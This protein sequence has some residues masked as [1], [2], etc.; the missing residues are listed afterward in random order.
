[1]TRGGAGAASS[2]CT[3]GCDQERDAAEEQVG[4]HRVCVTW[5][6]VM[7]GAGIRAL[8]A[9]VE[10]LDLPEPREPEATEVLIE[11]RAAG[12]GN[13]DEIA[14]NG[15]WDLGIVPPMA[16]GVEASGV[17]IAVGS[18]VHRFAESDEVLTHPVPLRHQGAWAERL[19]AVEATVA[20]K[21]PDMSWPTAALFPVPALTAGQVIHD[22]VQVQSGEPLLIHGAG[23]VTGGL[24]VAVAASAGARVVAVASSQDRQRLA[25]YGAQVV[26]DYHDPSWPAQ[27]NAIFGPSGAPAAV[28]TVRGGAERLMDMV[29]DSGRLV[30]TT[31]DGPPSERGVTVT[32]FYVSSDGELLEKLA[33]DFVA[34]HLTIPLAR[35]DPLGDAAAALAAVVGGHAG[36]GVVLVPES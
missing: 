36:G 21:P 10:I 3:D 19:V 13:W 15:G 17:V 2:R 20:R 18:A 26:L 27:A 11:V 9:A 35:S 23:G 14:R 30:T 5:S 28:N 1:M 33:F 16:L 31:S 32:N 29:A 8:G 6:K 7:Q 34:R 12:V 25:A 22:W 24:L 4:K